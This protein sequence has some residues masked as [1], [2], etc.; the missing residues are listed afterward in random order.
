MITCGRFGTFARVDDHREGMRW[1]PAPQRP[2]V[3]FG[4]DTDLRTATRW[5]FADSATVVIP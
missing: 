4:W 3:V 5:S 2:R 1:L